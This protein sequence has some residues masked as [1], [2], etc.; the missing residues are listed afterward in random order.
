MGEALQ[1]RDEEVRAAAALDPEK[2]RI[3]DFSGM[4]EEAV[5]RR[6]Q[7][8]LSATGVSPDEIQRIQQDLLLSGFNRQAT[9]RISGAISTESQLGSDMTGNVTGQV[10]DIS[11]MERRGGF[12]GRLSDGFGSL[13]LS[14]P[15]FISDL[16]GGDDNSGTIDSL[17]KDQ[18]TAAENLVAEI[19]G[20]AGERSNVYSPEFAQEKKFEEI[21]AAI[22]QA[23]A[24]GD[25]DLAE[26]LMKNFQVK[27]TTVNS[28]NRGRA[29]TEAEVEDA[30]SYTQ[31]LANRDPTF[32]TTLE[33]QQA[34]RDEGRVGMSLSQGWVT[35]NLGGN[36]LAALF[37]QTGTGAANGLVRDLMNDPESPS[38]QSSALM[39]S[40]A[41]Q[42]AA[43]TSMIELS[44]YATE[45]ANKLGELDDA[46]IA[47]L[48][49]LRQAAQF[50]VQA[51]SAFQSQSQNRMDR[52]ALAADDAR[53]EPRTKAQRDQQRQ[54]VEQLLAIRDE[55]VASAKAQVTQKREQQVQRTRMGEDFEVQKQ[56]SQEAYDRQRLR[57]EEDFQIQSTRMAAT[58]ELGRIRALE[59]Y[60]RSVQYATEDFYRQQAYS[61]ADYNRGV[62]RAQQDFNKQM[63][64]AAEDGARGV[65]D[66]YSRIQVQPIWDS[67]NLD[68]NL[69]EQ[70]Q[71]IADQ[72]ANLETLRLA[73]GSSNLI[74]LLGLNDPKNAQQL[75]QIVGDL[76]SDPSIVGQL[77]SQ[78][79]TRMQLGGQLVQDEDNVQFSRAR[80]DFATQ[81]GRG[82]E[83]F[84]TQMSR[85]TEAFQLSLSRGSEAF[86]LSMARG[87]EDYAIAVDNML[88]D[89][90]RAMERARID[91]DIAVEQM[92]FTYETALTRMNED[93]RRADEE[94]VSD[95]AGYHQM[96]TDMI[97]GQTVDFAGRTK[98]T[99]QGTLD[100]IA[101][102]TAEY[103][104]LITNMGPLQ[105]PVV[106]SGPVWQP[107]MGYNQ[108]GDAIYG[109]ATGLEPAPVYGPPTTG[110][111]GY[112]TPSPTYRDSRTAFAL[113]GIVTRP[114]EAL[115]GEA[116]YDEAV[117]P[118]NTQGVATLAAAMKQFV[119]A[120]DSQALRASQGVSITTYDHSTHVTD[121]SNRFEG[122][123]VV[124]AENPAKLVEELRKKAA[125]ANITAP[126]QR[127]T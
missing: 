120:T 118:L 35:E 111:T 114:T 117:I 86:S 39:A 32:R 24:N 125:A 98:S 3:M 115:I 43:G 5:I 46:T 50:Q 100:D 19:A 77:N 13:G 26:A 37:D 54:G 36:P 84:T 17:G 55:A 78:A 89:Y 109:P 122:P 76:V 52:A 60:Q 18:V 94:I 73:G 58:Y 29:F 85:A 53:I 112:S 47:F 70:N 30:G 20:R 59:D 105:V 25:R 106:S 116:G 28:E 124:N 7:G 107:P 68:L 57:A 71:A 95:L 126:P 113:G 63:E 110:K 41:D 87:A 8:G 11:G 61:Q 45:A 127:R 34:A 40:L 2:D 79:D 81:M 91:R 102:F 10:S 64:R 22:E 51:Q 1:V 21:D 14:M 119:S 9:G 44:K 96:M 121:H 23:F 66:A 74:Q 101:A 90:T 38:L 27:G 99:L 104:S 69:Q 33:T 97:N 48:G 12:A 6:I 80:E 82:L 72:L 93:V 88:S 15:R 123:I 4:S 92:L 16:F 108:N 56:W 62:L 103:E 65:Y 83:D 75:A 49:A 42:R 31:A 67:A